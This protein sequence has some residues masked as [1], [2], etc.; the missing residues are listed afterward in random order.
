MQFNSNTRRC[1]DALCVNFNVYAIWQLPLCINPA[2]IWMAH[3]FGLL[4]CVFLR[5]SVHN[6]RSFFPTA[7]PISRTWSHTTTNR[8]NNAVGRLFCRWCRR[9]CL[10]LRPRRSGVRSCFFREAT[11]SESR[12]NVSRCAVRCRLRSFV[13]KYGNGFSC[14]ARLAEFHSRWRW[15]VCVSVRI[16]VCFGIVGERTH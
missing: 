6:S 9:R 12:R 8:P 16:R 15:R 13:S 11:I 5:A 1:P 2:N 4:V 3:R 14:D 7:R 10:L